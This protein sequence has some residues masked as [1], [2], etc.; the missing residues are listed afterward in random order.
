MFGQTI[1]IRRAALLAAAVVPV[2]L[3][4]AFVLA[5]LGIGIVDALFLYQTV[6]RR[7]ARWMRQPWFV[8]AL[9][10][11]GWLLVCSVSWP[12]AGW[13]V[14]GWRLSFV[15]A[16]VIVRFFV[17]TAAL[18]T[19]VLTTAAARRT[20]WILLALSCLWIGLESWQQYLTG[21]NVFGDPRW[22][23]GA[24]TGPFWKPRA[25]ALFGHLLF[26][27]LLPPAAWLSARPDR[28]SRL[29]GATLVVLGMV[30]SVLIGQR[31]GSAFAILGDLTM[32]LLVPRL[33]PAAVAGLIAAAA[34]VL[35]T[36]L[37][38]PPTHAKLVVETGD[39]LH[40]FS[41][42]PYGELFT[43]AARMGLDSPWHGWGY[44]GFRAFC[45]Q[46]Q[47]AD[48]LPALGLPPTQLALGA[49]NLH[50]HNFYL[51]AFAD[52]GLPGLAGFIVLNAMWLAALCHGVWRGRDPLRVALL[53][54]GL[55]FIW[56]FASMDEFP[57]LYLPGWM[58]LLLGLGLALPAPRDSAAA[59][60]VY[61]GTVQATGKPTG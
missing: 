19:W 17:F 61:P 5:E 21:R 34:V 23:D 15:M 37:I 32:A 46:P 28:A 26:V 30:T 57:T 43:R 27:A 44:N 38:S 54:G 1:T 51:Q 53:I 6:R 39:N 48:G 24:L 7:D 4:H 13:A 59:P 58:F 55:T 42:S 14:P 60:P 31:M 52:A 16:L 50:P 9:L 10:W 29:A 47:F 3:L 22:P 56:P 25:G 20:A 33:R 2:G 12:G 40:H 41:S 18:Q 36:P 11:W 8:V 45:R 35:A 49:C